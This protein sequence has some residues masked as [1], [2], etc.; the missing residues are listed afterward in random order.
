MS[1]TTHSFVK[2]LASLALTSSVLL[3]ATSTQAETLISEGTLTVGME[4][5]YPPFESYDGDKVVGFDPELATLLSEQMGVTPK[6]VDSKFTN[7]ILGLSSDKFDTVISGMYILP[8]RLERTDAIAYARTGAHIMTLKDSE[9]KPATEKELCGLSVGLQQGTSWVKDLEALSTDYCLANDK[10][11]ITVRQY[12]TA[13]E[14]SQALLSRNIDAQ[15]EI[16]GA[17]K[18]FSERSRGRIVISSLDLI[19]PQ[20]LGIFVDKGNDV[21]FNQLQSAMDAIK[22][23]GSYLALIEKYELTPVSE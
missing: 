21:L 14:V 1:I 4:I 12:P 7:L 23:N 15:V 22:A 18:M 13:P 10:A 20:T 19:Y 16:A 3:A 9:Q 5:A 6:F 17:A 8:K 11:A 2:T